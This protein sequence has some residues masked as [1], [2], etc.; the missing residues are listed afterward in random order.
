MFDSIPEGLG[1]AVVDVQ[2][3]FVFIIVLSLKIRVIWLFKTSL[4]AFIEIVI[5]M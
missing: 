1:I 4:F 3:I 5:G 2:A